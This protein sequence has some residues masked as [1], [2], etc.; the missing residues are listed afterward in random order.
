MTRGD[1]Q[2][3]QCDPLNLIAKRE[4]LQWITVTAPVMQ[5]WRQGSLVA[6]PVIRGKDAQDPHAGR[7]V[8]HGGVLVTHFRSLAR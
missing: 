2:P 6:P 7:H 3:S 5:D 4:S 8:I 1:K